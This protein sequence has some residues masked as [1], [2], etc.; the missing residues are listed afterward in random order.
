MSHFS[1]GEG[2]LKRTPRGRVATARAYQHF[3]MPFKG[4]Q[5]L[6]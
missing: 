4:Q 2:Y 1:F 3:H 6:F 5:S